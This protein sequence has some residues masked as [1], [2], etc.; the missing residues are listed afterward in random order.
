MT[1]AQLDQ[2]I[3]ESIARTKLLKKLRRTQLKAEQLALDLSNS[4]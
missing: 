4:K 3:A 1:V 2:M